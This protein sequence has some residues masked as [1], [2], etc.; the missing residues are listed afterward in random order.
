MTIY[1]FV[2]TVGLVEG[3][4]SGIVGT[5]ASIMLLP[6]LVFQFAPSKRS[7]SWRSPR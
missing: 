1:I 3:T 7:R 4:L 6:I 2:L 5:G